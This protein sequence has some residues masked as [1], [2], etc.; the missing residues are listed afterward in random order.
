ME[1]KSRKR[2]CLKFRD[3][4]YEYIVIHGESQKKTAEILNVSEQTVSSWATAGKWRELRKSRQS[5]GE[6]AKQ[7]LRNIISLLSEQRLQLEYDIQHAQADGEKETE[8]NLRRQALGISDEI[9]KSNKAL[10]DIEKTG[11]ITLGVIIDV[12]STLTD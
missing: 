3:A 7:N 6:T 4:A 2:D 8:L 1:K 12:I 11:K 10:Q 5:A 9:S